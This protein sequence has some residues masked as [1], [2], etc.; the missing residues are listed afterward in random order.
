MPIL[1]LTT[2]TSYVLNTFD[3]FVTMKN[4][5]F[6]FEIENLEEHI[7]GSSRLSTVHTDSIK[8]YIFPLILRLVF[9]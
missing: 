5:K 7:P 9:I 4:G 8:T 3:L 2:C 1:H 6:M